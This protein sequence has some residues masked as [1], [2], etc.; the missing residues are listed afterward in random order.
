MGGIKCRLP[1]KLRVGCESLLRV[2]VI[3]EMITPFLIFR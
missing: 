2:E 1:L 3:T